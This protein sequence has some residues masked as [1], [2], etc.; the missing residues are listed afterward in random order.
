MKSM[1]QDGRLI[2]CFYRCVRNISA[3]FLRVEL[4]SEEFCNHLRPFLFD[5]TEHFI[6]EFI[7]Y[8]RSPFDVNA[9]DERA[10]YNWP[11]ESREQVRETPTVFHSHNSGGNEFCL[12]VLYVCL[13]PSTNWFYRFHFQSH[14][15]W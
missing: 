3:L 6:H 5:K 10:Q 13:W 8:A 12:F 9:Y 7:S 4:S 1:N 14:P 2:I 15:N 11:D